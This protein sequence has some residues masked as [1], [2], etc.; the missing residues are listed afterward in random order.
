MSQQSFDFTATCPPGLEGL[1]QAELEELGLHPF[2]ESHGAVG[3]KGSWPEAGR[4]LARSAIASRV[5]LRV[6]DFAARNP[7]MVYDQVRRLP[8]PDI[9]PLEYSFMI[10][11][12]GV[13]PDGHSLNLLTLKIKDA[14]CDEF[15][16]LKN[17]QRPMVNRNE[18]DVRL[19]AHFFDNRCVLSMDLSGVPLHRR[20]YR[21]DGGEAPLRENRAAALLRFAGWPREQAFLDPFCGSGTLV[22]EA[23]CAATG[24]APASL[25]DWR[26]WTGCRLSEELAAAVEGEIKGAREAAK[27]SGLPQIRGCDL[28]NNQVRRARE[29][30]ERAGFGK[31]VSFEV[32]DARK[33]EQPELCIVTNPPYGERLETQEDAV[34][35]IADFTRQLKHSCPGSELNMIVPRGALEKAVGFK[36]KRK[37]PF[38]TGTIDTIFLNFPIYAGSKRGGPAAGADEP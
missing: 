32:A 15:R 2:P 27:L 7:E 24:L 10:T 36:P 12:H 22:I 17:G 13:A 26:R 5:L 30:A 29:N 8:W 38:R 28:S 1:L 37:L 31:L 33:L 9:F 20:G 6:R 25:H 19:E 3:F 16:K 18:A 11:T 34:R 4:A 23:A 35:L 14:I 21:P